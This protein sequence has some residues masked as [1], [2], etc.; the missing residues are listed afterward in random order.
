VAVDSGRWLGRPVRQC[1]HR[2]SP[3]A[4][5]RP[6]VPKTGLSLYSQRPLNAGGVSEI[7]RWREAT[8]LLIN[9]TRAPAGA[10]EIS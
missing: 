10:M 4:E 3:G 5:N 1:W 9:K 7:S 2:F 8:G 6:A